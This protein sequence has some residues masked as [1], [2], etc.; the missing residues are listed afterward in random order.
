[1]MTYA[2]RGQYSL[3]ASRSN[4]EQWNIAAHP[5]VTVLVYVFLAFSVIVL[6]FTA[7]RYSRQPT[8]WH[9]IDRTFYQLC[10]HLPPLNES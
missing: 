5:M 9:D 2:R 1:M 10:F 6:S 3:L 7:G 4:W 8:K